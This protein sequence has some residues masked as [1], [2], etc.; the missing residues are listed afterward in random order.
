LDLSDRSYLKS[1]L[2]N[3]LEPVTGIAL[4]VR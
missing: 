1:N 3:G 2:I 4:K